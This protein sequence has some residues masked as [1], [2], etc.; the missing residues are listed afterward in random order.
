MTEPQPAIPKTE[1]ILDAEGHFHATD[2]PIDLSLYLFEDWISL[3][4]FW[5]LGLCVFYQFFTRYVLNDSYSWTEEVAT[6][7]L[8]V[9]VFV[10]SAMCVRLSRH[11]QV[12]LLYRFLSP[13]VGRALSTFIDVVRIAFFAYASYLVWRFIGIV[14]D[15]R[16]ITVD[17][18]KGFY[19]SAVFFGFVLMFIRS[20]QIAVQNWR[21]GFS[22][23]ERPE[24]FY[25]IGS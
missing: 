12:D 20:V 18:P 10:G 9:I 17:F 7:C 11:I 21:R 24:E 3:G 5:L 25:Q 6:Y 14:F 19:Y 23:L 16:M 8:V 1:P 15:E 2:A 22:V 4:F 13:R